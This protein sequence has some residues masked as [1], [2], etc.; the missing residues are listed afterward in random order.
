MISN[1]MKISCRPSCSS[2]IGYPIYDQIMKYMAKT[3]E[4]VIDNPTG[5]VAFIWS[6]LW[7]GRMSRNKFWWDEFRQKGKNVVVAEVG[8]LIR[9]KTWRLSVNGI[10]RSAVFPKI[11]KLDLDRPKKLGLTLE[12]WHN[13]D[14]VLICGQHGR[15]EQWRN[16]PD[17]NEYYKQTVLDIRKYT[18]RPIVIRS[19]P[20]FRE[21]LF[22]KIDQEFFNDYKIEW[23]SPKQVRNTYD[24][25]DLEYVLK[26]SHCVISHSSNSGVAAIMAGVPAIVSTESL[27]YPVATDQ[28]SLI[29]SLPKPNREEWLLDLSHKEWLNEELE[30]AWNCL[31]E[32]LNE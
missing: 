30:Y 14:Y 9:D 21:N 24:S 22:F 13:G 26:H 5:D 6:I 20:R 1:N 11:K 18:D 4:I 23:N 27:A 12:P 31:R 16:M 29:E 25:F 15:S 28:I 3:D 10:T 8:G 19:H 7:F 32:T 17:M 2:S